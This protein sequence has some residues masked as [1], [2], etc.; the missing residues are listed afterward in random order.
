MTARRDAVTGRNLSMRTR[1]VEP[2]CYSHVLSRREFLGTSAVALETPC[3]FLPEQATAAV[4]AGKHVYMVKPVAVD[5]PGALRVLAAGQ[6][7]RRRK[8]CFLIEY[9]MPTDPVNIDVVHRIHAGGLGEIAH[10]R[11]TGIAGGLKDPPQHR[12]ESHGPDRL[13]FL[14]QLDRGAQFA[15]K[16]EAGVVRRFSA[17]TAA[18]THR[19]CGAVFQPSAMDGESAES[20]QRIGAV[21]LDRRQHAHVTGETNPN[22]GRPFIAA[23][24]NPWLRLT[25]G[26]PTRPRPRLDSDLR[27]LSQNRWKIHAQKF[28]GTLNGPRVSS[29]LGFRWT[30]KTRT[31]FRGVKMPVSLLAE[32]QRSIKKL[33]PHQDVLDMGKL[34]EEEGF[35][36]PVKLPPRLISSQV[37]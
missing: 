26:V 21:D 6:D 20:E 19:R 1:N 34:A 36:P 5:V 12:G 31:Y 18:E 30:L 16:I 8:Q 11:S 17:A 27:T 32:M 15:A 33:I 22:F 9:E 4:A 3:Y 13:R 37:P 25:G 35:E 24:K 29:V 7:A 28:N 2:P 23:W 14:Q 10:L